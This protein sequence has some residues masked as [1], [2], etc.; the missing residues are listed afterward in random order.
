VAMQA[1]MQALIGGG[2]VETQETKLPQVFN[3]TSLKV[4]S[5]VETYR[6]YIR[7]KMKGVEVEEQ[8]LWV[9]SYIQSY[10]QGESTNM[11]KEKILEDLKE[12]L[13]KYRTVGEM[14]EDIKKKFRKNRKKEKE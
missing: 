11:W 14:L 9:L 3:G 10:V 2:A 13:W 4:S 7:K 8:I 12:R 5:F 6:L 1:Q